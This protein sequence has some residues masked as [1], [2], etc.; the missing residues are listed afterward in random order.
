ML[1]AKTSNKIVI[2]RVPKSKAINLS[3]IGLFYELQRYF[4]KAATPWL[5]SRFEVRIFTA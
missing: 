5:V 4:T 1:A 3:F 2:V